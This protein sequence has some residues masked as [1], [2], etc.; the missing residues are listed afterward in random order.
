ME[1]KTTE[2]EDTMNYDPNQI[3]PN[4]TQDGAPLGYQAPFVDQKPPVSQGLAV[5]SLICGIV[6]IVCC[7]CPGLPLI[8][9][10]VAIILAC[11][12]R[13]KAGHFRGMAIAGLVIGIV[14]AVY[15]VITLVDLI[16]TLNNPAFNE[17]LTAY[18][19]AIET[20]DMSKL[21]ELLAQYGA[22]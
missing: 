2:K 10:V 16:A 13:A 15:A 17:L 19:E 20:G 14:G 8:V 12:D 5:A 1:K 6:S 11:L 3:N 9:S 7:C 18:M 22:A 21:E 4:N